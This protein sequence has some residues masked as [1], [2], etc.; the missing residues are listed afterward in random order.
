[1][2]LTEYFGCRNYW[3]TDGIISPWASFTMGTRRAANS[4][5]MRKRKRENELTPIDIERAKAAIRI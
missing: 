2:R 1:M 4:S 5:F 3:V